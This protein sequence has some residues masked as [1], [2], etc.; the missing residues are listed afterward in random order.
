MSLANYGD[1]KTAIAGWLVRADLTARIP[2]F[3]Q[4]AEIRINRE[5]TRIGAGE[6]NSTSITTTAEA[7]DLPADFNGARRVAIVD[8]RTWPIE[9]RTPEQMWIEYP[10]LYAARPRVFTILG[11]DGAG[12]VNQIAFRPIPDAAYTVSLLY[13]KK[14]ATLVGGADAGT[15]WFMTSYPD[16]YLYASLLE[17]TPYIQ[18]DARVALWQGAYTQSM[19]DIADADKKQRYSGSV[20]RVSNS[21]VLLNGN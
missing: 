5:L 19:Q 8:S 17:A 21:T 9:Y 3:I 2:D 18:N 4:L 14:V 13:Y 6:L 10:A 16:A 15:N 7:V 1:L 20:L 12:G 11:K